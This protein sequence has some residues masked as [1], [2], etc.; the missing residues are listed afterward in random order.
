MD[1]YFTVYFEPVIPYDPVIWRRQM[2]TFSHYFSAMVETALL[3]LRNGCATAILIAEH[4][5]DGGHL[6][7]LIRHT[8]WHECTWDSLLPPSTFACS[9]VQIHVLPLCC[10]FKNLV[11]SVFCYVV[12]TARKLNICRGCNTCTVYL[13]TGNFCNTLISRIWSGHFSWYFNFTIF[14]K[15]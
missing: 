12:Y 6:S 11:L 5:W 4:I 8:W 15:L 14:G 1:Q 2:L 10:I 3:G 13:I 7:A 9:R